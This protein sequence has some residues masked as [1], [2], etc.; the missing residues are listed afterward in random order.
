MAEYSI[1]FA[2][3]ARKDIERIDARTVQRIFPKLENL[4]NQPRPAGC[5]KL[6]GPSDL[7][8]MRVGDYRV[9][10]SINDLT[11]IVD[12]TAIRHRR[13]AYQ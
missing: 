1:T 8:R 7:W 5:L 3:S 6:Q 11:R 9:I 13:E 10:Y 12:V 4:A 2:R